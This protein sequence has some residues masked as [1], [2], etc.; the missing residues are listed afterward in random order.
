MAIGLVPHYSVMFPVEGLTQEQFLALVNEAAGKLDWNIPNW[1]KDG[2]IAYT[3][4]RKRSINEKIHLDV[5]GGLVTMK[6]E[7][8]SGQFVDWGRNKKNLDEFLT[9]YDQLKTVFTPDQ[10]DVKF[11]ELSQHFIQDENGIQGGRNFETTEKSKGILSIFLPV[12]GY[13][14]TPIIIDLNMLVFIC[15]VLSGVSI[16]SPTNHNLINWGADF[17]PITLDGQ[18]WRLITNCFLHIGIFHLLFNMY[19]L[20]YIGIL[21]EPRL[22]SWRFGIAYL[23]TGIIASISSIYWHPM[24]VSAGAS[25][26]I[27]G[28]YGVFLAMLTT[29]LIE[30]T[31]RKALLTSIAIFVAY[32]LLNGMKGGID[33][34]AHIGG[35]ISGI[36]IGYSFYPGLTNLENKKLNFAL[37]GLLIIFL[38][39]FCSWEYR[40]IPNDIVKYDKQMKIFSSNEMKALELY[41]IMSSTTQE[42][43]LTE[44]KDKDMNLW[45]ENKNMVTE[46]D[47]LD[48]PA[49]LHVRNKKLIEY[50][51]LRIASYQL[52]YKTIDEN[53][54]EYRNQIRD[55]VNSI[56]SLI[57]TLK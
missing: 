34:A 12:K 44:I 10:L 33:N 29:N 13:A 28:M 23:V 36:V 18:S 32:N 52:I 14:V 56:D 39:V 48:L 5:E 45:N 31:Q 21:L 2:F 20:L 53:T 38:F 37:P 42:Q 55:Y 35:L 47:K 51:D 30:K 3:K 49:E 22:G 24:T 16:I 15:M 8:L 57:G 1:R 46:L 41:K 7:S 40:K 6:S 50:C 27:F 11:Q 54:G 19:A 17:R 26:A 9:V 25:G 4:F 43:M